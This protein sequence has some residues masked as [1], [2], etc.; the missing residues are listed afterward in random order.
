MGAV[1]SHNN[2]LGF[3]FDINAA[4]IFVITPTSLNKTFEQRVATFHCQH[5]TCDDISWRVNGTSLS[6]PDVSTMKVPLNGG[7]FSSSLSIE[8]IPHYNGTI[9]E[10]VAIF[11]DRS[12]PL[13]FTIAVTLLIQ[14]VM[15]ILCYTT[16][17]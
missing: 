1:N 15:T 10:C 16:I 5:L 11:F 6:L 13:Q 4:M 12:P 7:G 17:L 9:V 8:T 2:S 3:V 14:G